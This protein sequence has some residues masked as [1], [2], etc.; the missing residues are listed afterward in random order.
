MGRPSEHLIRAIVL[1]AAMFLWLN[2]FCLL[3]ELDAVGH[4]SESPSEQD[5]STH[6]KALCDDHLLHSAGIGHDADISAKAGIGLRA[7]RLA[8]VPHYQVPVATR[9]ELEI[10]SLPA[11]LSVSLP[12]SKVL[13]TLHSVYLI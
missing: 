12:S 5:H 8:G 2:P 7:A 3:P 11:P 9:S 4:H 1:I 10:A 6:P 13:Y